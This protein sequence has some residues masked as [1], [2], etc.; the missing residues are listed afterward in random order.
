MRVA[1]KPCST[2]FSLYEFAVVA[3]VL[4]ALTGILLLR[5][6]FYQDEAERVAVQQVASS[7]RIALALR[8]NEAGAREGQRGLQRLQDENPFDWLAHKPGN[9]LGEFYSP[10]FEK[11]PPGNW[12]FDRR[13]KCLLYLSRSVKKFSFNASMLTKLKVKFA[14]SIIEKN[15]SASRP[16]PPDVGMLLTVV[17]DEVP[18]PKDR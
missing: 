12:L 17:D 5:T 16:A 18:V 15:G 2:G 3:G 10:E 13:D 11:I 6:S 8:A 14:P 9:Y 1:S 7:L 4:G